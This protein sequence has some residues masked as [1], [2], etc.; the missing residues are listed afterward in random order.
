MQEDL[1]NTPTEELLKKEKTLKLIAAM[2][3]GFVITI[4]GGAIFFALKGGKGATTLIICGLAIAII[5]PMQF[6]NLKALR[7]EINRR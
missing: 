1:K 7:E 2:M 5:L 6:K 3:V 4:F